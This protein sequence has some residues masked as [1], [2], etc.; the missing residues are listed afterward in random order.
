MTLNERDDKPPVFR[1]Y[2]NCTP[3]Y[4]RCVGAVLWLSTL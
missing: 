2:E 1:Q 4:Q 3:G